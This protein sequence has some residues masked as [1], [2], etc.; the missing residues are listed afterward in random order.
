MSNI[1][2]ILESVKG[3]TLSVDEALLSIKEKPFERGYEL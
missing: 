1:K 2:D 3:G